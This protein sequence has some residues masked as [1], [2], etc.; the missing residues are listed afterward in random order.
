MIN[1]NILFYCFSIILVISSCLVTFVQ[2]PVFSLLFLVISFIFAA[3]LLFLLECE[4]LA[5]L[6]IIIYVGAILILFLFSI[7]M[8][9]TKFN[10]LIKNAVF[11][12]PIGFF[13]SIFLLLLILF[14]LSNSFYN[15]NNSNV[16][17]INIYQNW[18]NLVDC[19]SDINVY[20]QLLY[21]YYVFQFLISG[22][23][24]LLVLIGIISMPNM[25][26]IQASLDQSIFKQLS[27]NFQYDK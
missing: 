24:L 18:Y 11:Y 13:F 3:F 12:T 16:L 15:I 4:F 21:S 6:F 9:E 19:I 14:E 23:I 20:G 26:S 25:F 7:M 27:R 10:N 8:L 5:F 22:I 17:N 2:H 1:S